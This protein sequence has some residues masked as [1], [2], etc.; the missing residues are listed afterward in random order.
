MADRAHKQTDKILEQ[1]E[2]HLSAV[3]FRASK[4]AGEKWKKY[5][6]EIEPQV[7]EAFD[8]LKAATDKKEKKKLTKKYQSLLKE[9]TI[10]DA[11]YNN[12]TENL[13]KEITEI[14]KTAA[15]YINGKLPEVYA[16]NYNHVGKEIES[17][18]DGFSFE[19]VDASTVKNLATK[20][21]TLLPYKYI[22][23]KKDVRWNTKKVNAEVL[24][25]ILTG[26]SIPKI[27]DRLQNVTEMNRVS[28]VRNARTA[29]TGAENKGRIDNMERA[30]KM[31]INVKKEWIATDDARTRDWHADLDGK[32]VERDK[33]FVN[34]FGEIMFPG[35]P[36]ADPANVY[37][38]RCTLGYV[39]EGFGY[40]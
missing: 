21:K 23:G 29:V 7:K 2:R 4:S 39:I 17:A 36:T 18:V 26:D 1:M 37:N 14:N 24:Q 10:A 34:G 3:Y 33:P 35:D 16:L 15:A 32:I 40:Q 11:H 19:L 8:A 22:D 30:E 28:A 38:C 6:E 25:G 27:A 5:L 13:A 31:G 9:K 12:L 20:N